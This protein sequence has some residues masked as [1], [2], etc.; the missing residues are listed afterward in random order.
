M[1]KIVH[2]VIEAIQINISCGKA[3]LNYPNRERT[4]IGVGV[5]R[6]TK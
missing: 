5:V 4:E 2:A 6:L 3:R 1:E